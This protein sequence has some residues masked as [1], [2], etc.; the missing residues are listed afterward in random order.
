VT[1]VPRLSVRRALAGIGLAALVG[2]VVVA[3]IGRLAGFE[4][5]RRTVREGNHA[6]L[7]LCA[8]AQVLVFGGYAG[9][10]RHAVRFPH[11][12]RISIGLSLRVVLA[13][14]ALTQVVAAAGIGGLAVNYWALRRLRFGRRESAVRVIGLNTF[15]Y[16]VFALIGWTAALLALITSAAPPA[17]TIPWLVAIPIVLAAAAWFTAPSRVRHWTAP[18]GTWLRQALAVGVGAAWW[19][20]RSLGAPGA[21]RTT[22]SAACYWLGAT[23]S[24]WAALRAFGSDASV[25]A[26]LVA[27]ATGYAAQMIPVPLIAT[28]GIDAATTF[29]LHA[30]G[31]SLEVA[32]VAVVANRVFSFW[33]PLW[34]SLVFTALLPQTGR[35]LEQAAS[36]PERLGKTAAVS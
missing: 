36:A 32:L 3:G 9:V 31:V 11:G 5:L 33:L 28:G 27:F 1:D 12:P 4:D 26:I 17:M 23:L 19:V 15:V 14:F 22:T 21:T 8:A 29:A 6:W 30:V 7:A 24:L 25:V 34:P 16:L 35:R 18:G 10:Y 13:S 20:R 2:V